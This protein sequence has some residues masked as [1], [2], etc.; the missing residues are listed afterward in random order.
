MLSLR[1]TE[2]IT[3]QISNILDEKTKAGR[4]EEKGGCVNDACRQTICFL[5]ENYGEDEA[6]MQ[7]EIKQEGQ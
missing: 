7:Q 6:D 2:N 3:V 1:P 4:N 5:K